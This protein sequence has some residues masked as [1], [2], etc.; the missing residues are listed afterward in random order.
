MA[1]GIRSR[2]RVG[3]SRRLALGIVGASMVAA[4]ASLGNAGA[5]A[6]TAAAPLTRAVAAPPPHIMLIVEEN[7]AYSGIIGDTYA[8]Y[9][10]SLAS[11]YV[12]ATNWYA[13]EHKSELDYT[14]LLSGSNQGLPVGKPYSTTTLVDELHTANIPWKAYMESMPSNCFKGAVANGLY[15]VIHNPFHFFTRYTTTTGGWCS[16][17]DLSTEGIVRYPG[18]S[19]FITALDATTAPD[20]VY[21]LPNDCHEMHGDR[22]TGSTCATDSQRQLIAAG[23]SWLATN[24]AP[25]LKSSW[26]AQN[27]IVIITWDESSSKDLTGCCGGAATGGHIPT[28]VITSKNLGMGQFT[29]V[30]DHYGTLAAI[31][32][33]FGVPLL[34]NSASA[35]NGDLTGA[36][37]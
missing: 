9:L 26:F 23:D 32:K 27:G 20:F 34:L 5:P 4:I 37:G 25:V 6:E 36:F 24:L 33:A 35:V 28:I 31:E 17:A 29:T 7:R 2:H 22:N 30:G 16:S 21:L 14:D 10:N 13:V 11:K 15:D 18:S 1:S 3:R 12:S 19:A 8:P